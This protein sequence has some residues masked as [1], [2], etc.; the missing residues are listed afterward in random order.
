[1]IVIA[2][3]SQTGLGRTG[4]M[5]AFQH[6]NTV[7]DIVTLSKT[8]GCGLPGA[9]VSTTTEIGKFALERGFLRV[10]THLNDPFMAAVGSKVIEIVLRDDICMKA[11]ER[12]KQLREGLIR[13]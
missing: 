2:D 1:M 5:F 8:I 3:K 11:N 10:A 12:G 9:S 6:D 4:D 7:P 13:L